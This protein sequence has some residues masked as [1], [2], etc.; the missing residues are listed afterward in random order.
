MK[1]FK[2]I[3][4]KIKLGKWWAFIY[5]MAASSGYTMYQQDKMGL[6]AYIEYLKSH[7]VVLSPS[8]GLGISILATFACIMLVNKD[9]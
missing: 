6:D 9:G 7:W 4:E 1:R 3:S 8:I 5:G 2:N